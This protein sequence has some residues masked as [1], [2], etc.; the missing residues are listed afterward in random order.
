MILYRSKS[1]MVAALLREMIL[2]GELKPR[3]PLR[4]RDLAARFAV[5]ETPVREAL[6][7]LQSEG[8]VDSDV[9]KA[10]TVAEAQQGASAENSQIRAA[11]EAL[12]ISLAAERIR[13]DEL[14]ELRGL[15][16]RMM[17][18]G[19]GDDYYEL[20]RSF[21]FRIYEAARSP[22]LLTLMRLLWRSF[23]PGPRVTRSR[24]ES[25]RQHAALLEALARHDGPTAAELI[26]SH[27]LEL[28]ATL[29]A[30]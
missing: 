10:T 5:S 20:N 19:I 15:H 23:S 27:I 13:D 17:E 30:D 14:D 29:S 1:D 26:T 3:Q 21:H 25:T 4:Q 6:R 8:L 24:E 28:P 7:R 22:L 16:A 2:S 18:P 9:H 12:G 11:L